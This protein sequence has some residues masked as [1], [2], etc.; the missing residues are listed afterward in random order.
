MDSRIFAR[1]TL[2]AALALFFILYA[3]AP[4]TAAQRRKRV[5]RATARAVKEPPRQRLEGTK[6][7]RPPRT[8]DVLNYTIRT[9]F[10]P[11]NRAVIGDETVTLKPL[12]SGFRS[13][14]LDA[15]SMKIEAVTLA[16]SDVALQ[17]TQPPDKLAITLDRAYE[18]TDTINVRIRYR[19]MPT[20]GLYFIQQQ[21]RS[22]SAL[23]K[24]AQIWT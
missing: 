17:W 11:E 20:K 2:A 21:T 1:R 18:P 24:P 19:A 23:T 14:D 4:P 9:R 15:S 10:E 7:E 5:P 16:D 6:H 8:F 13:F 12:A 3:I 22:G